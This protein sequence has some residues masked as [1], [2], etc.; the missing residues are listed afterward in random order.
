MQI[1]R[2]NPLCDLVW[3]FLFVQF[4]ELDHIFYEIVFEKY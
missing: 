2:E 1:F 4:V 3:W